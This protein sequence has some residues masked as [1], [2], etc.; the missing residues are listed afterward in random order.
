MGE[1]AGEISIVLCSTGPMTFLGHSPLKGLW[2][3]CESLKGTRSCGAEAVGTPGREGAAEVTMWGWHSCWQSRK[4]LIMVKY[5]YSRMSLS[6]FHGRQPQGCK[7][8]ESD[9]CSMRWTFAQRNFVSPFGTLHEPL[10]HKHQGD[11][12]QGCLWCGFWRG[13]PRRSLEEE[14]WTRS[15]PLPLVGVWRSH[16]KNTKSGASSVQF[17]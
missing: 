13:R 7:M 10:L 14:W 15:S 4:F 16:Y 17:E 5:R 6:W 11:H 12:L 2:T 1:A 9:T 3:V 8:I